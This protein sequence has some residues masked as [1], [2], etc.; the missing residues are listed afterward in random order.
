MQIR[1]ITICEGFIPESETPPSLAR[2]VDFDDQDASDAAPPPS[3]S[4][5]PSSSQST[6]NYII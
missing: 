4:N 5:N 3:L 6:N 2:S 1:L